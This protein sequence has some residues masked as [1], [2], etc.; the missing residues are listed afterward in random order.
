ME[1]LTC[2]LHYLCSLLSLG[3]CRC[4]KP[5]YL[6]LS[7]IFFLV[8]NY[9]AWELESRPM[10]ELL[11]CIVPEYFNHLLVFEWEQWMMSRVSKCKLN[12]SSV[13]ELGYFFVFNLKIDWYK[14]ALARIHWC[15]ELT[16]KLAI[17]YFPNFKYWYKLF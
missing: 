9:C 8:F 4:L 3:Y 13:A 17:L 5:S 11:H 16:A 6:I 12:I 2:L 10:L 15:Q 7:W 1:N 14:I